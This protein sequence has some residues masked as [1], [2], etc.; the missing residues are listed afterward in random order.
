MVENTKKV[1]TKLKEI[2]DRNG[3]AY[4]TEEPFKVYQ[5]LLQ[6][7]EADRKAAGLVLYALVNDVQNEVESDGDPASLSKEIQRR[8]SLNKKTADY[9]STIFL[10]LYSKE[11]QNSWKEK[12]LE[13]LTQFFAEEFV[14]TWE[15]SAVWDI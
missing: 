3:L 13:R 12:N 7:K 11:N 8:C 4:L 2:I 6:S 9:L 5:E 10:N 14:C 15:G 1:A